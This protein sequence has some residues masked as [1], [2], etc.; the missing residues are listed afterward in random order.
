[1]RMF[2]VCVGGGPLKLNEQPTPK[3]QGTEVL[4]K[5]LAAGVSPSDLHRADGYFDLGGGKKMSLQDRGMKLPVTLGHE[6]VGEVT[7]VGPDAKGVKIGARMLADPWIG[8]GNCEACW[9]NE[10]NLCMAMRS[11]G[12]F[13]NGGYADYMMVPNPRYL[14]D[15]G[16]LPPERA[17]PLACSGV[18]TF[19]ALKK[20]TTLKREPTVIIG[21]GGLG[22]MCLALHQKMDGHSAIVVDID[23]AKREAA[24]KAGAAV[25]VD[26]KAADAVDQ[27]K[28]LT[29]GGAWPVIDLV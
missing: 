5:V 14:F 21:A 11:L 25:V 7:A 29:N 15:I 16:D 20:V 4:L 13:S 17:A 12:V 24:K 1:M 8:C 10:D 6:N 2:Q 9:R 27:I 26:P 22:L 28:A 23:P 18:T 3:P 19:G